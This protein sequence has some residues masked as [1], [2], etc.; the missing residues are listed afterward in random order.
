M[1]HESFVCSQSWGSAE[2]VQSSAFRNA[3][4]IKLRLRVAF[5]VPWSQVRELV[6]FHE[7]NAVAPKK[8]PGLVA[9]YWR[10]RLRGPEAV[11]YFP[12]TSMGTVIVFGGMHFS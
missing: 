6:N 12:I 8:S 10:R 11:S 5:E 3:N 2:P 7:I 1:E 9:M 4:S